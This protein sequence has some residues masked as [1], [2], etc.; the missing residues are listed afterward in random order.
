VGVAM[1]EIDAE[2]SRAAAAV[3][4]S[5]ESFFGRDH[6]REDGSENGFDA[7]SRLPGVRGAAGREGFDTYGTARRDLR[8]YKKDCAKDLRGPC[9]IPFLETRSSEEKGASGS[10]LGK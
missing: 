9:T 3:G 4:R 8:E 2:R 7:E 5:D 6:V 10:R 1:V